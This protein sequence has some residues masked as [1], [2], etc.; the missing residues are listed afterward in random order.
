MNLTDKI[1]K[2]LITWCPTSGYDIVIPNFYYHKSYE[3]DICQITNSGIVV[4]FEI[5]VSRSD[6]FKDFEKG[7]VSFSNHN[8]HT[9]IRDGLLPCNRFYFVVPDE[10]IK[11]DE[12]PAYAGLIYYNEKRDSLTRIRVAKILHRNRNI[13][14]KM[15]AN[16]LSWRLGYLKKQLNH[17]DNCMQ[18]Y[19]KDMARYREILEK[20]NIEV[21]F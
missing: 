4:E 21:P 3:M 10:M 13:D 2:R 1:K 20:N 9:L 5:K 8:K 11:P 7:K 14:Y 17:K 18:D 15:I 12:V 19:H 6:Y 16:H